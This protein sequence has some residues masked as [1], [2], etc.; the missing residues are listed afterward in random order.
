MHL[1]YA[2]LFMGFGSFCVHV[3]N[4]IMHMSITSI[5]DA[6]VSNVMLSQVSSRDSVVH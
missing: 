5:I 1:E 2:G 4:V 3:L 6:I